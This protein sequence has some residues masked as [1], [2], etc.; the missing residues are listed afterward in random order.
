MATKTLTYEGQLLGEVFLNL[1]KAVKADVDTNG[2]TVS[3]ID[4]ASLSED[5]SLL[6][7]PIFNKE[8]S[9]TFDSGNTLTAYDKNDFLDSMITALN[10]G[11]EFT[12]EDIEFVNSFPLFGGYLQYTFQYDVT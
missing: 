6:I 3:S 8:L 2:V 12:G 11:E 9:I 5:A 10:M 4:R 1:Y 7:L